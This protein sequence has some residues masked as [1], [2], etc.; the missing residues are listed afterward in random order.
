[1]LCLTKRCMP[2]PLKSFGST[3]THS[4]KSFLGWVHFTLC[5]LLNIIGKRF[6]DAGLRDLCIESGVI[7]EG[8][9]E[10]LLLG[11]QY[12]RAVR[13]HKLFYEALQRLAWI[14][15]VEFQD[16]DESTDL[17]SLVNTFSLE[18]CQKTF[19]PLAVRYSYYWLS[20]LKH[21]KIVCASM[22]SL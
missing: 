6:Q 3:G 5:T 15:F 4:Q 18:I 13:F 9:V 22:E 11:K 12:N 7:A 8:S 16:N 19:T 17:Q 20:V 10:K 21:T 14:G 2:K 1:M